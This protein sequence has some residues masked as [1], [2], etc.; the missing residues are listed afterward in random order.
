MRDEPEIQR[1]CRQAGEA[2][3]NMIG[4]VIGAVALYAVTY[5]LTLPLALLIG[6]IYYG[7]KFHRIKSQVNND[8]NDFWLNKE[9][10]EEFRAKYSRLE[11]CVEII[12][13]A[14]Q[15][16]NDEGISRNMD[17]TFSCRSNLGKEIHQIFGKYKPLKNTLTQQLQQ[18]RQQ[19]L[20]EWKKF[21]SIAHNLRAHLIGLF[22]F[23]IAM[24]CF[25]I[26][27][28]KYDLG[29][30]AIFLAMGIFVISTLIFLI[31]KYIPSEVGTKY[32]PKPPLVTLKNVQMHSHILLKR[33]P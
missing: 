3:G 8:F 32:S 15:R 25:A 19:P 14:E 24:G 2:A 6:T 13:D 20:A 11:Q 28:A 33:V 21:N 26:T 22:V 30:N 1:V 17:G 31:A 12:N 27:M 10:I 23:L 16:G 5:V 18:L 4:L 29:E 7:S 9:E